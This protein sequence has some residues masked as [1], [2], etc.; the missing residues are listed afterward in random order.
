MPELKRA[1]KLYRDLAPIRL[2]DSFFTPEIFVQLNDMDSLI[3]GS[4]SSPVKD[5]RGDSLVT[6]E[7]TEHLF[8]SKFNVSLDLVAINIQRGREHALPSY[9]AYRELC[10]VPAF[11]TWEAFA[12]ECRDPRMVDGLKRLYGTPR[13]CFSFRSKTSTVDRNNNSLKI[14]GIH[15]QLC[16]RSDHKRVQFEICQCQSVWRVD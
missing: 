2:R 7:L 11:N 13:K 16:P 14:G 10:G 9:N 1:D 15:C 6:S 12:E 4:V 8:P 5:I 3:R